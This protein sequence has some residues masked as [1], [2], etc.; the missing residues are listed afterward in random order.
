MNNTKKS[1]R[2]RVKRVLAVIW[3]VFVALLLLLL[4]N[5]MSAKMQGRVPSVGGYSLLKVVT[6][7][8]NPKIEPR[9]Y[10]LVRQADPEDIEAGDI[11]SFY[12]DD[13]AIKGMPNTH[14]VVEV[15]TGADGGKDFITKGDAAESNDSVP[16][17]GDKLIGVYV[18]DVAL[19]T[20][21][22]RR[23]EGN[24][25][26]L[27]IFAAQAAMIGMAVYNFVRQ[28]ALKKQQVAEAVD[29]PPDL[30]EE[31]LAELMAQIRA[32][33]SLQDQDKKD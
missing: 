22:A 23:L 33:A 21:F 3:W 15:V 8:M 12:S 26:F 19:L 27:V 30:T 4:V 1:T 29:M 6:P 18:T 20:W 13:S 32:E 9:T 28:R 10:I 25:L 16:A 5:V 11:I 7:S 24:G 17:D 14:R 31:K 2:R